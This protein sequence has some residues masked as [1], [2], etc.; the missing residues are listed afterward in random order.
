MDTLLQYLPRNGSNSRQDILTSATPAGKVPSRLEVPRVPTD[1]CGPGTAPHHPP[2]PPRNC[3]LEF[4]FCSHKGC[5][6]I[7][8]AHRTCFLK[9][10]GCTVVP[11]SIPSV[12]LGGWLCP[13]SIL[14]TTPPERRAFNH[15]ETERVYTAGPGESL[16]HPQCVSLHRPLGVGLHCP[17]RAGHWWIIPL[18]GCQVAHALSVSFHDQSTLTPE[19]AEDCRAPI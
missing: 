15:G 10:S 12:I 17:H 18:R 2:P 1:G 5:C 3:V 11:K 13:L 19:G 14:T 16:N 4:V 7:G 6:S 8:V 9:E